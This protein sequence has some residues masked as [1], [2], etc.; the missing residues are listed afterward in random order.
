MKA[1]LPLAG[2]RIVLTR[3]AGQSLEYRGALEA[4]GAEVWEMPVIEIVPH[5]DPDTLQDI[6]EEIATYEWVIFTSANGVT[7]FFQFF[8]KRFPDIRSIGFTRFACIGKATADK[9]R[10]Y[11][12]QVDLVPPEASSEHLAKALM[13]FQ[14][15]DNLKILVVTGN[16][17]K[18]T[19]VKTLEQEGRAIVDTVCVY[20]NQPIS[21]EKHP[22][23]KR[24]ISEGA[25]WILFTSDSAVE[26]FQQQA[27]LLQLHSGAKT[28]KVISIGPVTS[29]SLRKQKI[30]V[31]IE[32]EFPS[33]E[34]L[35]NALQ[36]LPSA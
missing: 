2:R 28:P 10:D 18:D 9:V 35:T 8:L 7:Q 31:A 1:S 6:W 24:F 5:E 27:Q 13:H 4:L 12:L 34:G 30:P 17:N 19:L 22:L 25:D 20:K 26:S 3:N 15:L 21:V 29:E 23:R 14:T 33:I 36:N 32:L 11:H 16:R